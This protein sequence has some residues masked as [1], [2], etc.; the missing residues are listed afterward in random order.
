MKK[1]FLLSLTITVLLCSTDTVLAQR[2]LG[3]PPPPPDRPI[4][5]LAQNTPTDIP[6]DG[7]LSLIAIAGVAYAAKKGHEKR[8][9]QKQG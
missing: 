9:K 4:D 8:K 2:T 3:A 1:F 7:G 5:A 6:F